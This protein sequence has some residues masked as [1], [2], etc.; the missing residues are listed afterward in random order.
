VLAF[1]FIP[2]VA[3]AATITV[4]SAADTVTPNDGAVTLREAMTS[5]M[6][7]NNL[8][9]ADI[10]AQAPGA[11]GTSDRIKFAIPGPGVHTL[12]PGSSYPT[13]TKAV[14]IDG[15]S[16]PGASPNTKAVGNDAV[17]RIEI[18]VAGTTDTLFTLEGGGGSIVRGI[19]ISGGA[20]AFR[21]GFPGNASNNNTIAGS[22]IGTDATGSAPLGS[23]AVGV[24]ISAGTGNR[25]GGPTPADRNVIVTEGA[26]INS[27][28]GENSIQGNYIG[29]NAAGT[30]V[31]R[32]PNGLPVSTTI[33]F[34]R[35]AGLV[36]GAGPGEGN[37]IL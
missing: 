12:T 10:T 2:L 25:I 5:I 8:G 33:E 29:I 18:G 23:Q 20:P 6:V 30:S 21:I 11:F 7:G 13:I 28:D 4:T 26:G 24:L 9:D 36:G 16:Q 27:F 32:N 37:V 31:V 1:S 17:L 14:F 3:Q 19:A 15:Y 34:V 35:S 22:F